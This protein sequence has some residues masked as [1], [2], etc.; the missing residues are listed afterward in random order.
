MYCD[1]NDQD[2]QAWLLA[3]SIS[4]D[5]I[6]A[7]DD[8]WDVAQAFRTDVHDMVYPHQYPLSDAD[9]LATLED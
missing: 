8:D 1:M 6:L 3:E 7:T 5:A 4:D 9:I 2:M